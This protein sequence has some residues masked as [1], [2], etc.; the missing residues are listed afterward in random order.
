MIQ[1]MVCGG[2]LSYPYG[3]VYRFPKYA[4]H[5]SVEN[6]IHSFK[7]W[8]AHFHPGKISA[9]IPLLPGLQ[10]FHIYSK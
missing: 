10:C 5:L 6:R 7:T 2:T 1:C 3:I 4:M 9:N 8:G